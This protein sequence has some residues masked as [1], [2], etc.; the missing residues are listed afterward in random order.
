M[1][2]VF[3]CA[4]GTGTGGGTNLVA[5]GS[6]AYPVAAGAPSLTV[7]PSVVINFSSGAGVSGRVLESYLQ[8]EWTSTQSGGT[9]NNGLQVVIGQ[10][11]R[12]G[13]GTNSLLRALVKVNNTG[14][15]SEAYLTAVDKANGANVYTSANLVLGIGTAWGAIQSLANMNSSTWSN[16]LVVSLCVLGTANSGN[17]GLTRLDVGLLEYIT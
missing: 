2:A 16:E 14:R 9:V 13:A 15:I 6:S 10:V 4:A 17:V 5:Y 1:S 11:C 3:A 8:F 12:N 7:T